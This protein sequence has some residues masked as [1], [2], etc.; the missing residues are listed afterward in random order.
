MQIFEN[1]AKVWGILIFKHGGHLLGSNFII[2]LEECWILNDHVP[3]LKLLAERERQRTHYLLDIS[4]E[5]IFLKEQL[6]MP[7]EEG[8][9]DGVDD[10]IID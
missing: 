9:L 4:L 2:K 8:V 6:R 7:Q 10:L 5:V 3:Y 1:F